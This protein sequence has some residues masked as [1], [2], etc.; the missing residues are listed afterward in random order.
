[1]LAC[2]TAAPAGISQRKE[3]KKNPKTQTSNTE[4][5]PDL[6]LL[7]NF[8]NTGAVKRG[9]GEKLQVVV[10]LMGFEV[11][12]LENER[13]QPLCSRMWSCSDKSPV[14]Q[15]PSM[16]QSGAGN[17]ELCQAEGADL[18][19][20]ECALDRDPQKCWFWDVAAQVGSS[21]TAPKQSQALTPRLA[22]AAALT[23]AQ[24]GWGIASGNSR[25]GGGNSH[26]FS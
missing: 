7:L 17:T 24:Q 26:S 4:T 9:K 10:W 20:Q 6:K 18:M 21:Q 22:G 1:M 19:L 5:N 16:F 25:A 11:V 15:F 13:I 14:L 23:S 12:F 3:E 8:G 2:W